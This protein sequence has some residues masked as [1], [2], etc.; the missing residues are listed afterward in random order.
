MNIQTILDGVPRLAEEWAA[1]RADRQQR[2]KGAPADFE[3][4][5]KIGIPMMS[6]P[7]EFGGTWE[8]QAQSVRPICT[9]LRALAQGDPSI[10]LASAMHQLVLSSWRVPAVPEPHTEIW[11]KQRREVFQTVLDGGWWGT[12]ISEPG[13]GGDTSKSRAQCI[14]EAPSSLIYRMSGQKHFGSGSGL[15][16]FMTTR[17]I[18]EGDTSPDL[19][20]IETRNHPW[21]GSTGMKLTGEWLGHGMKATNSHAF[22]FDNFPATRIACPSS[23]IEKLAGSVGIS[24]LVFTSVIVGVVDAAMNYTRERLGEVRSQGS[25]LRAFQQVEWTLA[26]EESWVIDQI[27]ES[28]VTALEVDNQDRRGNLLAKQSVARLAESV[29]TRLCKLMGGTSYTLYS[30]LGSWFE[31]VRALGYLRPPWTLAFDQMYD[32]TWQE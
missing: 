4:L 18:A 31:D 27:W 1:Q 22:F 5:R 19:F 2:T 30:P 25:T 13:T 17:A 28:A 10:T 24:N 21:D 26:D 8:T 12:I 29:L 11:A 23:V 9:M 3:Q 16:S 7:T 15:T 20:Y 6:V 32:L 14:P